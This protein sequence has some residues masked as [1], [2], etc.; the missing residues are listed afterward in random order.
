MAQNTCCAACRF[1]EKKDYILY[2]AVSW[3][4]HPSATLHHRINGPYQTRL[5]AFGDSE[6][7]K[8]TLA[9]CDKEGWFEPAEKPRKKLWGIF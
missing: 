3:C 4:N 7:T 8:A 2:G 9:K 5:D 1:F 6:A